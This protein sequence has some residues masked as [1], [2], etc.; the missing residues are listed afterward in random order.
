MVRNVERK[1]DIHEKLKKGVEVPEKLQ[2][3]TTLEG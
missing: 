1:E 2:K 3:F